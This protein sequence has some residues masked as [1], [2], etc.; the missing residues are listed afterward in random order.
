MPPAQILTESMAGLRDAIQ[1]AA[2]AGDATHPAPDDLLRRVADIEERVAAGDTNDLERE[3]EK[4]SA[5]S[6][7]WSEEGNSPPPVRT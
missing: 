3:L 7:P 5:G 1:Q 4:F 6:T 2:A